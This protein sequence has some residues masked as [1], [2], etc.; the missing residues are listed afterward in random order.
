MKSYPCQDLI[1]RLLAFA[2][3]AG[4]GLSDPASDPG[5][6]PDPPTVGAPAPAPKVS[7]SSDFRCD[8]PPILDPS[9]DR[10]PS[11]DQLFSSHAALM[12]QVKRHQALVRIPSITYD[13]M[14]PP[15]QDARW[16]PFRELHRVLRQ[17]YPAV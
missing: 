7:A 1:L 8:L 5:L 6:G 2:T 3:S 12:L 17:T 4:L 13:D 16:R 11:A 9:L 14:G 10:L 15:D